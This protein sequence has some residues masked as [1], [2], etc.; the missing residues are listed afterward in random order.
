MAGIISAQVTPLT[1]RL[2]VRYD[3]GLSA[4]DIAALVHAALQAPRL[5]HEAREILPN[6]TSSRRNGNP[7]LCGV[8]LDHQG[9]HRASTEVPVW[10]RWYRSLRAYITLTHRAPW[11]LQGL[12]FVLLLA[13]AVAQSWLVVG[14]SLVLSLIV[15]PMATAGL[16][17]ARFTPLLLY[18]MGFAAWSTWLG[19]WLAAQSIWLPTAFIAM[20][21]LALHLGVRCLVA[22]LAGVPRLLAYGQHRRSPVGLIVERSS[23]AAGGGDRQASRFWAEA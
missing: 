10:G 21:S 6:T 1:G 20:S 17:T 4:Q 9:D 22:K 14:A 12:V 13:L 18:W 5:T 16:L 3:T 2:L 11:R 19:L 7:F 15:T 23:G 8:H